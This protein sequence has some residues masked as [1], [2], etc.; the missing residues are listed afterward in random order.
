[1]HVRCLFKVL[2][3][4]NITGARNVMTTPKITVFSS[5]K[6]CGSCVDHAANV[7]TETSSLCPQPIKPATT[8]EFVG[9]CQG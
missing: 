1:M 2:V 9:L 7:L 6:L 3:A 8:A 5:T 4:I